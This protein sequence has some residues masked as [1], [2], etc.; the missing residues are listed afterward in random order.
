VLPFC[1]K[2]LLR[3]FMGSGLL[4]K[5]AVLLSL[6]TFRMETFVLVGRIIALLTLGTL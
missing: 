2:A 5:L 3:F 6:D 4:A 1:A